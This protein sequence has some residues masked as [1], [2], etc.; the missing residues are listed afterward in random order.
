M[1]RKMKDSDIDE[2]VKDEVE[3]FGESLGDSMLKNELSNQNALYLVLE[4]D[5]KILGYIGLW[6]NLD[7]AQILNFYI[8]KDYRNKGF[9]STLLKEAI[10]NLEDNGVK[11][12]SL[13]VRESNLNAIDLYEKF[14]FRMEYKRKYYYK[15]GEDAHVYVRRI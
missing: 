9:G 8:K 13:E 2:I 1:I 6:I 5:N 10:K 3:I 14:N 12:I 4:E 7:N 11:I 15:D